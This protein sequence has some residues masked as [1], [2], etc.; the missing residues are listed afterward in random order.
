MNTTAHSPTFVSPGL[1]ALVSLAGAAES[2]ECLKGDRPQQRG[3]S[4][5]VI[6]E[7]GNGVA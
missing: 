3:Y 2:K 4:Q 1:L 6:T 7:G 5:A